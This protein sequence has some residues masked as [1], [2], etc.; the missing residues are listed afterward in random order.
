METKPDSSKSTDMLYY[1]SRRGEN[2]EHQE[3]K[4]LTE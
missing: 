1:E 2:W 4:I 3:V